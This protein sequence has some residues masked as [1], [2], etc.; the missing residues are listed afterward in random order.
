[1]LISSENDK[2]TKQIVPLDMKYLY[3]SLPIPVSRSASEGG[4]RNAWAGPWGRKLQNADLWAEHYS[5]TSLQQLQ[6]LVHDLHKPVKSPARTACRMVPKVP[7]VTEMLAVHI[8]WGK[9]H[10][11]PFIDMASG[12]LYLYL[13]E[14]VYTHTHVT[15]Q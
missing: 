3:Q 9:Q 1:M 2:V 4:G 5:F 10:R 14:W 7:P 13:W 15:T 12:R 11:F 8:F 6:L